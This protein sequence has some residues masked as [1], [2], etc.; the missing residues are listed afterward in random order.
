MLRTQFILS[1]IPVG[2]GLFS[3]D[4]PLLLRPAQSFG[5]EGT[6][7]PAAAVVASAA[8]AGTTVQ[9]SSAA[10]STTVPAGISDTAALLAEESRAELLLSLVRVGGTGR[11]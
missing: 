4:S 5:P 8:P 9:G 11:G 7:A 2:S 3:T 1:N 10:T 6:R